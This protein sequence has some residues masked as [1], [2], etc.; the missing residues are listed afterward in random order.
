MQELK[1]LADKLGKFPEELRA[2]KEEVLTFAGNQMLEEV[3]N[4]IDSSGIQDLNGRV[5]SW[6]ELHVGSGLGYAAVRA[7]D[8]SGGVNSPGAITTYLERGHK[9][10]NPAKRAKAYYFYAHSRGVLDGRIMNETKQ[11]LEKKIAAALEE[12]K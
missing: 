11:L 5:K 12:L 10:R 7:T 9:T 8:A 4:Q 3:R 1:L 2:I 6:Q